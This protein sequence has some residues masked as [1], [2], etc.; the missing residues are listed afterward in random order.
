MSQFLIE[1]NPYDYRRTLRTL[2]MG[3]TVISFNLYGW[4]NKLL[5]LFFKKLSPNSILNKY[6]VFT[7]TV[8]DQ[9]LFA[10]YMAVSYLFFISLFEFGNIKRAFKNIK[11]NFMPVIICNYQFWPIVNYLNF[12]FVPFTF[13]I[14][15]LN[16][17]ALFWNM[18]LA[19]RNQI[20]QNT[21]AELKNTHNLLTGSN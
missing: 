2:L 21:K 7:T 20:N 16:L 8:L 15:V 14:V 11:D 12:T 18:Y 19:H 3:Y 10:P 13:R 17:C 6:N 5:P 4:Y 9:I 1:K